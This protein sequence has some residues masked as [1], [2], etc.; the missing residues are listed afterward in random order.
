MKRANSKQYVN[1]A[2]DRVPRAA[3]KENCFKSKDSAPAHVDVVIISLALGYS[4]G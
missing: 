3:K 1:T 2:L 4:L